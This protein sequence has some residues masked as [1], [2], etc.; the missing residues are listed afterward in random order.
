MLRFYTVSAE[1]LPVLF[2]MEK[3]SLFSLRFVD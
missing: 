3:K 2:T 1:T